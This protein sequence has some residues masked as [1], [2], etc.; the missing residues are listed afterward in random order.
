VLGLGV[1]AL[2]AALGDDDAWTLPHPAPVITI[3]A[4]APELGSYGCASCHADVAAEWVG[5]AHGLSWLDRD[6]QE[7]LTTKRVPASCH[8]CHVPEPLLAGGEL[9]PRV[10]AREDD[11]HLGV[12]C[13]TCHLGPEGSILGPQ[14]LATDAHASVRSEHFVGAGSTALCASCHSTNIGPVIGVA[15]DFETAEMAARGLTCVGCHMG[16]VERRWADD[17]EVR[18]AR[19]HALQTPR[20]P[21]FLRLAF[22]LTVR[23][24]GGSVH[25]DV[26]NQAGHR[27]PGLVG[28]QITL[29]AELLD[30]A[31]ATVASGELRIDERRYLP[32]DGSKSIELSGAGTT[33]R[34]VG[35]HQDP[36]AKEAVTFL[37]ERFPASGR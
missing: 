20:D 25:L 22:G 2:A 29:R 36:R 18:A 12:R 35:L 15:K 10:D 34:V 33:V 31:G 3:P 21:A 32:V 23:A 9:A 37:D 13:E 8:A 26:A 17:G 16:P 4:E 14:G 6:Y 11:L 7:S 24:E 27:V 30:D 28:R 1:P 5:S 19:S